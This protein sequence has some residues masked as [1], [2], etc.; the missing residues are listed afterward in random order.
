MGAK[1]KSTLEKLKKLFPKLNNK[2]LSTFI[3]KSRGGTG[4]VVVTRSVA[5]VIPVKRKKKKQK[6]TT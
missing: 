4:A 2:Q 5:G 6:S 1:T 3:K